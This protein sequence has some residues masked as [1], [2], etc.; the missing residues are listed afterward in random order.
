M[1]L[2]G[3][4]CLVPGFLLVSTGAFFLQEMGGM[5]NQRKAWDGLA[6][7]IDFD[8]T[9][10]GT[11]TGL[12]DNPK[13]PLDES[14]TPAEFEMR[15]GGALPISEGDHEFYYLGRDVA[16]PVEEPLSLIHI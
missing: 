12:E 16:T 4:G 1:L 10:R 7:L 3:C 2:T 5:M 6:E 13:T 15:M 11:P 14:L 8:P 9:L